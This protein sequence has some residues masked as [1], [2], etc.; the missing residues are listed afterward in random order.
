MTD[1]EKARLAYLLVGCLT[2]ATTG[3][4]GDR[5]QTEAKEAVTNVRT[6]SFRKDTPEQY[7]THVFQQYR[8]A[9]S[10]HDRAIV[11]LSYTASNRIENKT[12]PLHVSYNREQLFVQAYDVQLLSD[13]KGTLAWIGDEQTDNFD[14]Q[15]KRAGPIEARPTIESLFADPILFQHVS[16]GLAGPPPQ[17]EWLFSDEPM[18]QF[19]RSGDR[20]AFDKTDTI[21][22]RSCRSVRV[23]A[24]PDIYRFWID[25]ASG[26]VRR[27]EFPS[28]VAP[29]VPGQPPLRMTLTMDLVGASFGPSIHAPEVKPLPTDP[30]YVSRFIPLPPPEPPASLGQM[31]DRFQVESTDNRIQVSDRGSNR[32][33]T[34]VVRFTGDQRSRVAVAT[35]QQWFQ[36]MPEVLLSR[37]LLVFLAESG[38][39]EPLS[40]QT[41]VPVVVDQHESAAQALNLAP[42]TLAIQDK[43]GRIHWVQSD[44][45]EP[46][47][48]SLGAIVAD[49]V[50]GVDVP[51]RVRDQWQQQV[52]AYETA[53]TRAA[54]L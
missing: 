28:M 33:A 48:I 51:G 7:L 2:I 5:P 30:R 53:M 45:S 8:E 17:L 47:L 52:D 40:K 1:F 6:A 26:I 38:T 24:G 19:F 36:Q 27:I 9:T 23:H 41:S 25:R 54:A 13:S 44:F 21:D 29:P 42:G 37:V 49:V 3:G 22:G 16:A 50:A 46:S 18:K 34:L 20:F 14:S 15:V 31:P 10:Y 32:D 12:A 39:A 35:L 43:S 11:R 4:C